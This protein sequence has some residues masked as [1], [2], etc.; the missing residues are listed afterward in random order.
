MESRS[1]F[2]T[3]LTIPAVR[4]V[5]QA[6]GR[7]I[8]GSEETG[9][10]A[11]LDSRY[12]STSWD[13]VEEYLSEQEQDEFSRTRSEN[14]GRLVSSFWEEVGSRESRDRDEKSQ[15]LGDT[16]QD[17]Q[18]TLGEH[19]S[20]EGV[21]SS[22]GDGRES[23]GGR[24]Y[25]VD[26]TKTAKIYFGKE[27]DLAGWVTLKKDIVEYEIIPLVE[28]YKV[29]DSEEVETISLNF[30]KEL[31]ES[32]WTPIPADVVLEKIEPIAKESRP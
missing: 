31:S 11:L 28:E 27:A 19:D 25:N 13:G 24:E 4:K 21:P 9:V 3:A 16:Q 6:F 10:R 7:V 1:G 26:P 23:E 12:A 8:R 5:R 17:K 29:E 18:S 32:G 22:T 14:V 30:S 20:Q 2:E 15:S